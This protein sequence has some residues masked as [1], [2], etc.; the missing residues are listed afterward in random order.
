MSKSV[1]IPIDVSQ[2][3]FVAEVMNV[4][5][6]LAGASNARIVL[7]NVIEEIPAY[8]AAHLPGGIHE[9]AVSNA[10]AVLEKLRS[11]HGTCL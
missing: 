7:L 9:K 8:V 1:L 3:G 10:T 11:E 2:D 4:A 6:A 5:K